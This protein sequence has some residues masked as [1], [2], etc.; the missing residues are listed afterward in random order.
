[1]IPGSAYGHVSPRAIYNYGT[2]LQTP[3]THCTRPHDPSSAVTTDD[4]GVGGISGPVA[5]DDVGVGGISGSVTTD[6][7]GFGGISGPTSPP[8]RSQ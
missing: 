6:D 8:V 5:I 2:H 3:W 7:V 4:V 1:M